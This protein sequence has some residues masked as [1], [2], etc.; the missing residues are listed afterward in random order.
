[1]V[2]VLTFGGPCVLGEA[3]PQTLAPARPLQQQG[4]CV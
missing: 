2:L 4:L 1:M 3:G